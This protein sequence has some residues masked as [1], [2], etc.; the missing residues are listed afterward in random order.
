M[1]RDMTE[2]IYLMAFKGEPIVSVPANLRELL[3]LSMNYRMRFGVKCVVVPAS[4][5]KQLI[6]I[7]NSKGLQEIASSWNPELKTAIHRNHFEAL[8]EILQ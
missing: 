4:I 8:T 3:L 5:T 2:R 1:D 6:E 7:M